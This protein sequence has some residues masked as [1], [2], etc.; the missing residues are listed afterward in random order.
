MDCNPSPASCKQ[1][2]IFPES[3]E[4]KKMNNLKNIRR[5]SW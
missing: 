3:I 2:F 5:K 1:G 4:E